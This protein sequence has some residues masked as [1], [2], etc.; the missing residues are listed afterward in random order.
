[1]LQGIILDVDPSTGK[2]QAIRRLQVHHES[3]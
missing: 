1:L 2:A 3:S